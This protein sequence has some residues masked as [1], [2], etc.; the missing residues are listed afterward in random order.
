MHCLTSTPQVCDFGR[1]FQQKLRFLARQTD[2]RS[3][4]YVSSDACFNGSIT[5]ILSLQP[6]MLAG[7]LQIAA[8]AMTLSLTQQ[9]KS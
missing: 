6:Y 5:K 3:D 4:D 9:A 2:R 1:D 8:V 7:C